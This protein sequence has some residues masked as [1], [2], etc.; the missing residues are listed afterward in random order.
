MFAPPV[1]IAY[2]TRCHAGMTGRGGEPKR[3][4]IRRAQPAGA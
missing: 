1:R 3:A 4:H 2:E